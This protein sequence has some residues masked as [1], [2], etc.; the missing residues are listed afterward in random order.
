MSHP[1][2]ISIVKACQTLPDEPKNLEPAGKR[3]QT[4][5]R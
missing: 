3:Y 2:P 1:T 4:G 5:R